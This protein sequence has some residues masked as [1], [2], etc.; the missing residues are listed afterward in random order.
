M[1]PLVPRRFIHEPRPVEPNQ[2]NPAS[3][4]EMEAGSES[5]C[6]HDVPEN[7]LLPPLCPLCAA[8]GVHAQAVAQEKGCPTPPLEVHYCDICAEELQNAQTRRLAVTLAS[9]LFS[10]AAATGLT[11]LFGLRFWGAQLVG[12][13]LVSVALPSLAA[14]AGLWRRDESTVLERSSPLASRRLATTSPPFSQALTRAGWKAQLA[15]A[16]DSTWLSRFNSAWPLWVVTLTGLLSWSALHW[17][18]S[19]QI[20]VIYGGSGSATL[21]IDGRHSGTVQSSN[22][23]DPLAGRRF[24]VLAGRRKLQLISS[25]GELLVEQSTT[26]WPQYGYLL[27]L[28]PAGQCLFLES[29]AY[30]EEGQNHFMN[31]LPG[32]GPLWEL[33]GTIDAWFEGLGGGAKVVS[34]QSPEAE[35]FSGGKRRA[36]RLLPCRP[37]LETSSSE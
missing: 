33:E 9:C 16:P 32:D 23:E 15:T 10:F 34:R 37:R 4:P 29:R 2:E 17:A 22:S 24:R 30:G 8:P 1:G 25:R 11:L 35:N 3:Q 26:L 6:I 31:R 5:L 21:L 12:V 36:I 13:L 7:S 14:W 27:A 20:R 28:P 19:T 18:G